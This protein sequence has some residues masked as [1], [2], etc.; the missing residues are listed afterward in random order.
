MGNL[1]NIDNYLIEEFDKLPL[2]FWDFKNADT[3]ELTHGI[4]SYPAVMIYPICRN[5]INIVK[6]YQKLETILDPFLGSGTTVIE[7]MLNGFVKAYGNDLNPL[8]LLIAEVRTT[9]L[10]PDLLTRTCDTLVQDINSKFLKYSHILE[11]INDKINFDYDIT[12]KTG[13]GDNAPTILSDYLTLDIEIPSFRN[14]GYWFVPSAIIG[15]QLIKE[16]I[17]KVDNYDIKK[18]LYVVFSETVRTVSNRRNGEFKMYRMKKEELYSYNPDVKDVFEKNLFLYMKKMIDFYERYSKNDIK[19]QTYI[20]KEDSRILS[21][22]PDD[23]IDIMITSPPYGDS[24]TTVA[25]GE[26]SRVSLQW[27]DLEDE[28]VLGIDKQLMGGEKYNQGVKYDLQSETLNK[29]LTTITE[30]D[31]KRAEEVYSFYEDLNKA[32]KVISQKMKKNSYQFWVVGNRTVK[33]EKLLTDKIIT[34]LAKQYNLVHVITL[35][36]NIPNKVMP[37]LNSPSNIPGETVSTMTNEHIVILR[38]E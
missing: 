29:S 18:F 35:G 33:R 20:M 22:V 26:F 31:P 7:G 9:P 32:I 38:K 30:R 5:I 10:E 34:E 11:N 15:L 23:S 28:E 4:H 1:K 25:Y 2:D 13:W 21:Y 8:A 3:K 17:N 36:R 37:S 24:R 19:T 27:L 16:S 14:I 12:E 6:R